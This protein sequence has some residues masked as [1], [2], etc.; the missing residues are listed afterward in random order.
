MS[1]LESTAKRAEKVQ[2][3][4]KRAKEPY[5]S[6]SSRISSLLFYFIK[7]DSTEVI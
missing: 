4:A 6:D 3:L 7:S 1:D 2:D 5:T